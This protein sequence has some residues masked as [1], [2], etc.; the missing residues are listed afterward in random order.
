MT[1]IDSHRVTVADLLYPI[2]R[3][4]L[5]NGKPID[6]TSLTV[7]FEMITDAGVSKIAATATGVTKH[8]TTTFTASATTDLLTASEHVVQDGD[9]IVVSNSGGALPTGLAAS[10][11]YFA[12]DVSANAFRLATTPGGAVIDITGAGSGANSY[13]IVGHVQYAFVSAG[14]DTAGV[15][16]AWFTLLDGSSNTQ[17]V[18][19]DGRRFKVEVIAAT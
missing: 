5:K 2:S 17:H 18:P 19:Q 3:I 12:R 6:L 16:W 14:V 9:E 15:Y 4:L 1:A 10:T 8:P 13:Y 11:R 7:K